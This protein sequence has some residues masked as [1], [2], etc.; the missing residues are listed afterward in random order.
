DR[1]LT[2][3]ADTAPLATPGIAPPEHPAHLALWHG[4][5]PALWISLTTIVLG[6]LAFWFTRVRVLRRLFRFTAADVYNGVLRAVARL[7][8]ITTR[9]TQRG[10]LPVYVGT[11]FVVF[12][13]SEG[14]ALIAGWRWGLTL[15][16]WQTPMQLLVAPLM[17][18]AG[19][20]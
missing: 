15:D 19:L 14:T 5:E 1:A 8:V 10:S 4:L 12:V 11:I 2:G 17:I 16:G 9:F 13:A 7:S 18:G 6:A 20:L 3:Y